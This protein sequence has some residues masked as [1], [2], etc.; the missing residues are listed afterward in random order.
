LDRAVVAGLTGGLQVLRV[1]EQ[2]RV[3]LMG[4]TVIDYC[5]GYDE[6][7][8]FAALTEGLVLKLG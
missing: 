3:A 4:L 1:S 7:L 6:A 8:G 5:G 2:G